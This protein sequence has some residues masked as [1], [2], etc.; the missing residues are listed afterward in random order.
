M[1]KHQ[2]IFACYNTSGT[3]VNKFIAI[4]D[5]KRPQL[6][7]IRKGYENVLESRLRDAYFFINEDSKEPLASKTCK[8]HDIIFLGKLGTVYDKIQR[9]KNLSLF[10]GAQARFN[11]IELLSKEQCILLGESALLCKTDLVTHLV[12]EFPELQGIA[13]REYLKREGKPAH[14]SQAVS[15]HYLP[16]TLSDSVDIKKY[17]DISV[18]RVAALLSILDKFDTIIGALASG[19]EISGSEDPYALRRAS[20]G[21][22]KLIRSF[23]I[24]F[25]ITEL[26]ERTYA[27]YAESDIKEHLS[28][29]CD[30]ITERALSLLKERFL[31][32]TGE[33]A[34]SIERMIVDA[35]ISS[36]FNDI[37]DVFA[38]YTILKQLYKSKRAQFVDACKIVERTRNILKSY[39]G[40]LSGSIDTALLVEDAEKNLNMVFAKHHESIRAL[41]N[42]KKYDEALLTFAE[43]FK[44]EVHMFFDKVLVNVDDAS[45]RKNRMLLMKKINE[46]FTKEVADL[47]VIYGLE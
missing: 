45:I 41:I 11:G 27:A 21:I 38:R 42:E 17:K 15:D 43:S 23:A 19:I 30:D 10:L 14:V 26:I 12:F 29:S 39:S 35:V 22:I 32:E 44:N 7:L 18:G 16:K 5:G 47:A 2:K 37:N 4:I 33:P 9:L 25:S 40:D 28:V 6:A 1:K 24:N 8:L 34:G 36:H 3:L 13:G 46:L 20:G 31:Y